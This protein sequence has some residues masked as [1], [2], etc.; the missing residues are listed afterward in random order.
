MGRFLLVQKH[1]FDY[2]YI[3]NTCYRHLDGSCAHLSLYMPWR[4]MREW[5]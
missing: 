4:H 3:R 2:Q 1:S 5:R